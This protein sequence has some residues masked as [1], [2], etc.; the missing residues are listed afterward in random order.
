MSGPYD[1]PARFPL[2]N[3]SVVPFRPPVFNNRGPV[4][5]NMDAEPL[6]FLLAVMRSPDQPMDRRM[7]AAKAAAPYRHTRL[8]TTSPMEEGGL[9]IQVTGGLPQEEVAK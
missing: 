7:D 5:V 6:D 3:T 2:P 8:A 1:P 4:H 9:K